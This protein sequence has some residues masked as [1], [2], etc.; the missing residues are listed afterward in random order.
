V[1]EKDHR[2]VA[3]GIFCLY[4][5]NRW[6]ANACLWGVRPHRSIWNLCWPRFAAGSYCADVQRTSHLCVGGLAHIATGDSRG[7][8]F[9]SASCRIGASLA[10]TNNGF[11]H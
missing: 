4:P 6:Q 7:I 5:W 3:A 11:S 10:A 9:V 8:C 1:F 2:I